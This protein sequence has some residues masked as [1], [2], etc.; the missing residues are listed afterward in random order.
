MN[1]DLF[2]MTQ[3]QEAVRALKQDGVIAYPT[4]TVYGVGCDAFNRGAVE[5]IFKWK[6]RDLSKPLSV[7]V[8]DFEMMEQVAEVSD[9][10]RKIC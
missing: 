9:E 3:I 8:S 6:H 2:N 10:N 7:A 1:F 5:R 4:D